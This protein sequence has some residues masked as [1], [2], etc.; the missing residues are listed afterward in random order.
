MPY[1]FSRS[2]VKFQGHTGK[3]FV[4]FDPNWAFPDCISSLISQLALKRCTKLGSSIEVVPYCFRRS[5]V[6]F[7][8][9]A[10][11]KKS[12]I[13]TQIWLF[14]YLQ[15]KFTD[16]YKMMH[17]AWSS[18]EG[19]P[20]CFPRSPVKLSNFKVTREKIADFDPNWAFPD[21]HSRLNSPM[22]LKWCTKLDV[23]SKRCPIVFQGHPSIFKFTRDKN[24]N[25]DPNWVFPDRDYNLYS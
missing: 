23:V 20:L 6:K 13:L 9:R 21:C 10:R 16:G 4:D 11:Q 24:V 18:M 1:W 12:P 2:S 15:F 14:L 7:K 19:V 25:F 3:K 5:S 17:K 8:G 22:A